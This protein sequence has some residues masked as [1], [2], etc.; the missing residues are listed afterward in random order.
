Q[1]RLCD[2]ECRAVNFSYFFLLLFLWSSHAL[3]EPLTVYFMV[4]QDPSFPGEILDGI[5]KQLEARSAA[6]VS[7]SRFDGIFRQ[8]EL[9]VAFG[10]EGAKAA[11]SLDPRIP[12]LSIFVPRKIFQEIVSGKEK[13]Q[14][15]AI[16]ID[17]PFSR[18]MALARLAFPGRHRIGVM[19]GPDSRTD[20]QS[21]RQAS[22]GRGLQ[23]AVGVTASRS[24]LFSGL[25]ALLRDSDVILAVP[26]PQV[27]NSGTISGI[28]LTAYRYNVPLMGFSPSYVKAGAL[29][30]LYSTVEQVGWQVAEAVSAFS[31]SGI[32]PQP[33]YPAYFTVGVNRYVARSMGIEIQDEATFEEKLS[34][35]G[36]AP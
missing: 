12:V 33:A 15:T 23:I 18:Q 14:V 21:L 25:E 3:G 6:R 16:Y 36:G 4:G 34:H 31:S 28:L 1:A 27:F 17:Q 32:L 19:L 30:A 29:I 10:V 22:T 2:L 9:V 8:N 7:K 20:I 5:Q 11:L 24:D 13:R 35:M 26:D